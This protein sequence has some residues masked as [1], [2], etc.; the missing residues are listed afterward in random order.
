MAT[1]YFDADLGSNSS[2]TGT[3]E[4]P[5]Q[6]YDGK[7]G[8]IVAGDRCLFKRGTLQ[9]INSRHLFFRSGTASTPTY[10]GV[11]G[12]GSKKVTW[13]SYNL[14]G[15]LFNGSNTRYVTLEDFNFDASNQTSGTIYWAGQ[16]TG[17]TSNITIR[18]CNFYGALGNGS[19]VSFSREQTASGATVTNC[20][21]E[22]CNSYE[23]GCH[24][25]VC[26]GVSNITFRRC[27]SWKNGKTAQDGGHG[28]SARA[29]RNTVTS[30]W[31][32]VSG[33]TYSR[34]LAAH[35]LDVTYVQSS[36]SY[37]RVYKN[38]TTPTSP[39]LG[40]FG[41]NLGSFY[42]NIGTNPNGL[43][44]GYAFA[45]CSGI[46]W[47][48]CES[49]ENYWNVSTPYHEGHG[50]AFDDYTEQ[51][52]MR[53][54][55]SYNNQGL[56]IS[57]NRGDYNVYE[58]N[59]VFNNW[60]SGFTA[61]PCDNLILKNN[62][63]VNNNVGIGK[64]TGEVRFSTD[65]Q[66]NHL[67]VN[68]HIQA[69]PSTNTYGVDFNLASLNN[70]VENSNVL[71]CTTPVRGASTSNITTVNADLDV[72][73]RPS[74]LS[75]LKQ[76]GKFSST[77]QSFYNNSFNVPPTIGAIECITPKTIATSRQMRV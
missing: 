70:T 4:N 68:C 55:M 65:F 29:H 76:A 31:T 22:D 35:E 30:G 74:N 57:N 1:Y 39:N 9:I 47:E 21:L 72:G 18:R 62:T 44:V 5:W 7:Q 10:Y 71:N 26:I 59:L 64:H 46:I 8:S 40:E 32:L 54:C 25:F 52:I 43:S 6:Y 69:L 63:F 20:L 2:G 19:G 42:I 73:F 61:N 23:N 49:F 38:T 11:Y 14:W 58:S 56:G 33:T 77:I 48:D 41:V 17:I 16:G 24:G 34:T 12:S 27:K 66:R 37:S 75:P 50:F 15:Y 53:R 13:Y 45:N 28:F 60:Q 67:V 3:I 36:S 51:S